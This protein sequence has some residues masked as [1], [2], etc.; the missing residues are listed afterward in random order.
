MLKKTFLL[1]LFLFFLACGYES[2]HSKKNI[3][4]YDF[5]INEIVFKGDRNFN[6][7][8]KE[9]L[10]NHT[11]NKKNKHFT[12]KIKSISKKQIVGKNLAGDPISFKNSITMNI[13]VLI[14]NQIKET[15]TI[16]ESFN[17]NNN[18]DKFSLKKYEKEIKNNLAESSAKKL[19]FK[20]SNIQ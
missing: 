11:L 14:N 16:E 9:L 3:T 17:Y 6:L 5:S 8:I 7:K 1:T 18:G 10:N 12:L 19:I 2:M 13:D 20:L 15:L 4:N